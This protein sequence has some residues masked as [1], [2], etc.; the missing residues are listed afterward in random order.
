MKQTWLD[1]LLM[2]W[3]IPHGMMLRPLISANLEIESF[4]SSAWVGV[5]PFPMSGIRLHGMPPIPSTSSFPEL[6]VRTYVQAEGKPG[7]WF[8]SLDAA[9]FLAVHAARRF[10]HLPYF[11]ARMSADMEA[12]GVIQL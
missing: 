9:N 11:R 12:T 2:H 4:D 6:N 3:P 7:V 8:F 10:F 5:V 1:L